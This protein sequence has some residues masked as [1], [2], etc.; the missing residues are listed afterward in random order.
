MKTI[1]LFIILHNSL[2][3]SQSREFEEYMLGPAMDFYGYNYLNGPNGGKGNTGVAGENDLSGVLMNPAAFIMNKKYSFNLQYSYKTT[4]EVSY[5]YEMGPSFR[6]EL[7]HIAPTIQGGFG[8]MITKNLNAG[9]LYSN[10]NS[11]KFVYKDFG[12]I[13]SNVE[14]SE[15][16]NMHSVNIPFVYS[17]GKVSLGMNPHFI[18]VKDV[19]KGVSTI[20]QPDGSGEMSRYYS[21]FNADFGIRFLSGKN[22]SIGATF[23]PSYT[24]DIKSNDE[25]YP[26]NFKAVSTQPFKISA[27]IEYTGEKKKFKLSA[28]YNFQQTSKL[29]GYLD[30]HDFNIGGEYSVNK[31]LALRAGFFTIFDIRDFEDEDVSFPG[32]AGDFTQY[33]VTCGLSY[34]INNFDLSASLMDSH[35]SMGLIKLTIIN[36]GFTYGF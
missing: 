11:V 4:N 35:V 6:Y 27:G 13:Q 15:T 20:S 30:K 32:K 8:M 19:Y 23:T 2:I 3:F 31:S 36:A 9:I 17:F 7:Q 33:F 26:T 1:I 14:E 18:Y 29:N 5:T 21:R 12:V 16:V 24:A 22:F 25:Y 10:L 34:K 28:D